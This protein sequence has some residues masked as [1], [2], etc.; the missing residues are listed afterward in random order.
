LIV[1]GSVPQAQTSAIVGSYTDTL[2]VTINY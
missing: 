2:V 1:Y